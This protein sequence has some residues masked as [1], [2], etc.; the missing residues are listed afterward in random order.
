MV[1]EPDPLQIPR[2]D[3]FRKTLA[4]KQD[5]PSGLVSAQVTCLFAALCDP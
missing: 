2:I 3:L 4:L 5:R 1:D